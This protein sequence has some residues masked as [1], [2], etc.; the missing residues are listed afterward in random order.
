MSD[1][2]AATRRLSPLGLLFV[3]AQTPETDALEKGIDTIMQLLKSLP[4]G[5]PRKIE[6][7]GKGR[8]LFDELSEIRQKRR[9]AWDLVRSKGSP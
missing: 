4:N 8:P 2:P 7:I 6:A 9:E 3:F 1:Q 5:D